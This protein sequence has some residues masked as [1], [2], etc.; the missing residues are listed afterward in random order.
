M[1]FIVSTSE[2]LSQLNIVKTVINS[3]NSLAILDNFLFT[4][5][6]NVLKIAATDLETTLN[7]EIELSNA[8]GDGVI[9]IEAKS[10]TD[11]LK[12]FTDQPLT[13][14]INLETYQIDILST[15]GKFSIVGQSGEEF[16][17]LPQLEEEY[18]SVT[19]DSEILQKGITGTLFATADD[20]MRPV[21]NG[22]LV[23]LSTDHLRFVATDSH[24]LARYTRS[25]IKS[26]KNASFILPKKTANILKTVLAKDGNSIT[27]EFDSKNAFFNLTNYRMVCRLI[28]GKY[29]A[30]QAVIPTKNTNKLVVDRADFYSKSKIVAH[31][32][33]PANGMIKLEMGGSNLVISAQDFDRS[34]SG[35]EQLNCQYE[36][37]DLT[38]G[39]KSK[40]LR[41]IVENLNSVEMCMQLSDAT[42]AGLI[43][44]MEQEDENEDIL[45]L[46]MPMLV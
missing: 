1:E 46:I 23:E 45:M 15:S 2:L 5:S 43:V 18:S 40:Y 14:K 41:E 38:I 34:L 10:L 29:P 24:K 35:Q 21:M 13:F 37:E 11:F 8:N 12:E 36:G 33:N 3:K 27:V 9:A 32:A 17:K 28:E 39:F 26:D 22:I 42:R 44:P 25:D 16:P 31:F 6:G 7:T 30:Y 20:D 19:I 4:L